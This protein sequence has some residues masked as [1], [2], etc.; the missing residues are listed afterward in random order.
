MKIRDLVE[1]FEGLIPVEIIQPEVDITIFE[2]LFNE[3]EEFNSEVLG[4]EVDSIDQC[5]TGTLVVFVK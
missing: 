3:I 1:V 5:C 2:G 4:F